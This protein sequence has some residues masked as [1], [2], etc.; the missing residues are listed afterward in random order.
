MQVAPLQSLILKWRTSAELLRKYGAD[1]QARALESCVEDSLAALQQAATETLSPA[2]A[3][4]ES[5][6]TPDSI[7]RLM[8]QGKLANVGTKRRPRARRCDIPHKAGSARTKIS[9]LPDLANSG[10]VTPDLMR[11]AVSSKLTGRR[12]A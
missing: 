12:R 10:T 1:E 4:A 7:T 5:G 8:R 3:A 11:A 6:L 2:E 9:L